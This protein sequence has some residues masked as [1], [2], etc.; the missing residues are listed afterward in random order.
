[1]MKVKIV[2]TITMLVAVPAAAETKSRPIRQE[3]VREYA[4]KQIPLAKAAQR[5]SAQSILRANGILMG[6]ADTRQRGA[7]AAGY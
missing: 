4:R 5:G 7:L 6:A 1:M 3:L 2:C